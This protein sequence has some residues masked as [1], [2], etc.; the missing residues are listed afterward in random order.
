MS[1][2]P[3]SWPKLTA[4][5]IKQYSEMAESWV[6]HLLEIARS[7]GII[8]ACFV[9]DG[10][11]TRLSLIDLIDRFKSLGT[12]NGVAIYAGNVEGQSLLL[13]KGVT[14]VRARR[15]TI[16]RCFIAQDDDAFNHLF[17]VIDPMV[18][19]NQ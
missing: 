14:R 10:F 19:Y 6:P 17:S 5:E 3:A 9:V 15:E 2:F 13:I 1:S 7:N 8:Y 12:K 18:L 4:D 11:S 16:K